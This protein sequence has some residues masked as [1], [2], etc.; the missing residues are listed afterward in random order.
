VASAYSQGPSAVTIFVLKR[1]AG[2][3]LGH[4]DGQYFGPCTAGESNCEIRTLDDGTQ[5]TARENA[6]PPAM[7]LASTLTA[8]RPDGTYIQ[9]ISSVGLGPVPSET[10]RPI[11]AMTNADL[12]KF[13]TVFT[14][15]DSGNS[16]EPTGS[17]DT[18]DTVEAPETEIDNESARTHELDEQLADAG[19]IPS[20]YTVRGEGDGQNPTTFQEAPEGDDTPR[21]YLKVNL[22]ADGEMTQFSI[23]VMKKQDA[24]SDPGEPGDCGDAEN[25]EQRDRDGTSI[26]VW[27]LGSSDEDSTHISA[28]RS[29]DTVI[30]VRHQGDPGAK[31]MSEDEL[32]ELATA[33]TY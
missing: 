29:D 32:L 4:A 8:Q 28:L 1:P 30:E 24:G 27:D 26:A 33:F 23:W 3:P 9:V 14:L 19:G 21:V 16:G 17:Q 18:G 5:A 2:T 11:P 10:P 31:L 7:Q 13:A 22:V 15:P 20:R 6:R 25:C 12:F